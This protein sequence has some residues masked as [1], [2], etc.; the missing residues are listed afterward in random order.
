MALPHTL[1]VVVVSIYHF[2]VLHCVTLVTS[3]VLWSIAVWRFTERV[4]G[5]L[6]LLRSAVLPQLQ[7]SP[8]FFER[9]SAGAV[10]RAWS[11]K[12]R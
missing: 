10:E 2:P 7:Y 1:F 5:Y 12:S 9:E 4:H 3:D 8:F 11:R 6:H